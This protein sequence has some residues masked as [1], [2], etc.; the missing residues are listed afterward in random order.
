MTRRA[1]LQAALAMAAVPLT[2]MFAAPSAAQAPKVTK[3][4]DFTTGADV[5][6]AE[7]EGEVLFYTHDSEPAAA[8]IVEAF[9]KD[10]PK[11]KG[12]YVRAQNGALFSKVLAERS[13]GK[14]NV[15]V[16]QFSEPATA[17]DLNRHVSI[18]GQR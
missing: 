3:V 8:G 5:A 17:L 1:A 9:S 10:F 12:R 6:Q 15:D 2:G 16:I 4:L 11:I 18:T 7:Q 13:A 14:F